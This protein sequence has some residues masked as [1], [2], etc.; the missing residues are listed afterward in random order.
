[1]IL[2]D[3]IILDD[4]IEWSKKHNVYDGPS[5][6]KF[7]ESRRTRPHRHARRTGTNQKTTYRSENITGETR[8]I[9]ICSV[10]SNYRIPPEHHRSTGG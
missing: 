3:S 2:S 10:R 7:I 5:I 6:R 1:M 9:S 8:R 4:L